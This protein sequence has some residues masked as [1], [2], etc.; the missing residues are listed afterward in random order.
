MS[1]GV[2]GLRPNP[3]TSRIV[4]CS[5]MTRRSSFEW[6]NPRV[7]RSRTILE[8]DPR[9]RIKTTEFVE[10]LPTSS[11]W[12]RSGVIERQTISADMQWQPRLMVL[13]NTD[14]FFSKPDSDVI[15]DKLPLRNI[16]FIGKVETSQNPLG[17][18]S[19]SSATGMTSIPSVHRGSK[20]TNQKRNTVKFSGSFKMDHMGDLQVCVLSPYWTT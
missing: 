7:P 9:R 18:P 2:P 10:R 5:A 20:R 6:S 4:V 16:A 3:S 13:T 8:H 15:L 17:E 11:S 19:A 14:I 12:T 1:L